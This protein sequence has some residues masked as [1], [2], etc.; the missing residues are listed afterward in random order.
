MALET[1]TK[2]LLPQNYGD[3]YSVAILDQLKAWEAFRTLNIGR[4]ENPPMPQG[5]VTPYEYPLA[6]YHDKAS[7][8]LSGHPVVTTRAA[9]TTC[10][11]QV[12]SAQTAATDLKLNQK[13]VV[14]LPRMGRKS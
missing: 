8:T 3:D 11:S 1:A 13:L 7:E 4:R 12:S 9:E 6:K 10:R 5:D 14:N 2:Q